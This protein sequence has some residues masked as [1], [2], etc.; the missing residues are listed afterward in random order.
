M[1]DSDRFDTFFEKIIRV[2]RDK[3]H[4]APN[5]IDDLSSSGLTARESLF[6][7]QLITKP[8]QEIELDNQAKDDSGVFEIIRQIKNPKERLSAL[9][10]FFGSP[11]RISPKILLYLLDNIPKGEDWGHQNGKAFK[12]I[13]DDIKNVIGGQSWKIDG[14]HYIDILIMYEAIK[15]TKGKV[16]KDYRAA[17]QTTSQDILR[18]SKFLGNVKVDFSAELKSLFVHMINS[19]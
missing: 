10:T 1:Y 12:S 4:T 13:Y 5:E 7:R 14:F 9:L 11:R 2:L 3:F 18:K 19:S 6:L 17:L 8:S 15:S 16:D